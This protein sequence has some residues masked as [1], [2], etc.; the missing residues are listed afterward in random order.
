MSPRNMVRD[1]RYRSNTR[2]RS[3]GIRHNEITV[4]RSYYLLLVTQ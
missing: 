2:G 4:D 3:A 1:P